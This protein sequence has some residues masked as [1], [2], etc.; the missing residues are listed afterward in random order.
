MMDA[1]LE[2]GLCL[3]ATGST[4]DIVQHRVLPVN[5]LDGPTRVH[6][7]LV[8]RQVPVN[9]VLPMKVSH[10]LGDVCTGDVAK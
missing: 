5:D 8:N 2:I 6:M 1:S 3:F 10:P 9:Q 7:A 4:Y